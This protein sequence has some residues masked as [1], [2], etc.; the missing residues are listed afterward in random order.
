MKS[1][2]VEA[3]SNIPVDTDELA[4]L[5]LTSKPEAQIRDRLAYR[6]HLQLA[7][8]ELLVAREWK[9]TDLAVLQSDGAPLALIEAKALLSAD[10]QYQGRVEKWRKRVLADINKARQTAERADAQDSEVYALVIV[11]HVLTPVTPEQR[12]VVKYGKRLIA[13]APWEEAERRDLKQLLPEGPA[14]HEHTLGRG[15]AFGIKVEVTTWLFGPMNAAIAARD[16]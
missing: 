9:R 6:L 3:I 7:G 16:G 14:P 11:T 10:L 5:A 8:Q 1:E 15:E 2:L 13:V 4:Y 12:S